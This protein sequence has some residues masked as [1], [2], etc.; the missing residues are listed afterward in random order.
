MTKMLVRE[1]VGLLK[2]FCVLNK[3]DKGM[4]MAVKTL[5]LNCTELEAERLFRDI[6]DG[7]YTLEE[8]L[9]KRG[10]M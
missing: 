4:V 8:L 1:K 5:L 2:D 6:L 3:K 7:V 9:I 10:L